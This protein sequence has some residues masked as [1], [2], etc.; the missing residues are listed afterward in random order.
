MSLIS[1][2]F[3]SYC[4][5]WLVNKSL[6]KSA[7]STCIDFVSKRDHQNISHGC[8]GGSTWDRGIFTPVQFFVPDV[9][10]TS[11]ETAKTK[12]LICSRFCRWCYNVRLHVTYH[13]IRWFV[14]GHFASHHGENFVANWTNL[15]LKYWAAWDWTIRNVKSPSSFLMRKIRM[16]NVEMSEMLMSRKKVRKEEAHQISDQEFW[17]LWVWF[18]WGTKKCFEQGS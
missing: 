5:Y 13:E 4:I 3:S 16:S 18:D 9:R 10:E 14:S 6:V 11:R 12:W 15:H 7:S 17:M 2:W 8:F 1:S